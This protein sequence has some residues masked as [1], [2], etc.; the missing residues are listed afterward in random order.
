MDSNHDQRWTPPLARGGVRDLYFFAGMSGL[1][2][3]KAVLETAV[4]PF[5]HIPI[6]FLALIVLLTPDTMNQIAL[7]SFLVLSQ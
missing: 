3:E 7:I 2:P 5:H 1:E 6:T 4:I